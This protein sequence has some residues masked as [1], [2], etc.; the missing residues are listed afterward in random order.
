M[1]GRQFKYD[2]YTIEI[3]ADLGDEADRLETAITQARESVRIYQV[4]AE[5]EARAIDGERVRV[6]RKRHD[7]RVTQ[8]RWPHYHVIQGLRGGY[9]PDLNWVFKTRAEAEGSAAALAVDWRDEWDEDDDGEWKPVYRVEG[10]AREGRYD[11]ERREPSA[12]EL[13][14]YIEI[15]RCDH[16]DCLKEIEER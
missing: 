4:P 7:L 10:S 1:N 16:P 9:L 15:T 12:T 8:N 14:Y 6:R 5:W 13:G 11:I 2:Y 3:P